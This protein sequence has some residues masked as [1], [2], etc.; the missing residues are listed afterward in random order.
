MKKLSLKSLKLEAGDMLQR[1]QLKTVFGGYGC[2][3]YYTEN[4]VSQWSAQTLTVSQ[5][6]S[7]YNSGGDELFNGHGN[8]SIT[9]SGY[10]CASCNEFQN[11]PSWDGLFPVR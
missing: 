5:A 3:V 8:P 2:S 6:Q 10:C 1:D 4:G 9:V 7:A 11:H